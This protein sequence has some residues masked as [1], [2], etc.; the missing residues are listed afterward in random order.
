[1]FNPDAKI[2]V[3]SIYPG[4]WCCVIDEVLLDPQAWVARANQFASQFEALPGNA[5]PG[6][7][8]HLPP[9]LT[10]L[11]DQYLDI[12][13][14]Y[15]AQR[16]GTEP[17]QAQ[18]LEG[19]T[20]L[21]IVTRAEAALQPYQWICHRDRLSPDPTHQIEAMVLYLFDN[22]E[23]G[24]TSFYRARADQAATAQLVHDSGALSPAQFQ[25][26]YGIAPGYMHASNAHF[27]QCLTVPARFNRLIFYSGQ[28]FHSADITRPDLLRA[29]PSHGR[30]TLNGFLTRG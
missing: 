30:L 23:L 16:S 11:W 1:M 28:V 7:E 27:E 2:Q 21:G 20:R 6:L 14:R 8:L 12:A 19:Y 29:D 4:Q 15:I 10:P 24:G 22:P 5:Y 18:L 26:R 17:A 25:S 13:R 3:L 9:Q